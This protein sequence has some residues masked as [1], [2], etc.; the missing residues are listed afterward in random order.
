MVLDLI[1]SFAV[2]G[3]TAWSLAGLMGLGYPCGPI[4]E[5]TT[6]DLFTRWQCFKKGRGE[7]V[8]LRLRITQ[9]NLHCVLVI[10]ASRKAGPGSWSCKWL[11]SSNGLNP[12]QQNLNQG[13]VDTNPGT[14]SR[15]CCFL[16]YPLWT[17]LLYV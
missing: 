4:F 7:I 13:L 9:C 6:L 8:R 3:Q 10:R 2:R 17:S 12:P 14:F 11:L 15:S 1:H 5:E 16:I